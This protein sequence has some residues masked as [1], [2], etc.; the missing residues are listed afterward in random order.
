MKLPPTMA[1]GLQLSLHS[2]AFQEVYTPGL[3]GQLEFGVDHDRGYHA[4]NRE[5]KGGSNDNSNEKDSLT[6]ILSLG[7]HLIVKVTSWAWNHSNKKRSLY[8]YH[9]AIYQL[10][11]SQ[12]WSFLVASGIQNTIG[13]TKKAVYQ[14][15]YQFCFCIPH[16]YQ[17]K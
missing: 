9:D 5:G 15:I 1:T 4:Q 6:N 14:S 2:V 12:K 17:N 7:A 11:T 8:I 16:I 13:I 10:Y 3:E